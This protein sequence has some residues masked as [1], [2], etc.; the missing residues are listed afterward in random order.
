MKLHNFFLR[1]KMQFLILGVLAIWG[2]YLFKSMATDQNRQKQFYIASGENEEIC[3]TVHPDQELKL[4]FLASEPIHYDIHTHRDDKITY[5]RYE[6]STLKSKSKLVPEQKDYFCAQWKNLGVNKIEVAY[7]LEV[8]PAISN[9][10]FIRKNVAFRVNKNIP[11]VIQVLE[12]STSD[13]VTS[14][15]FLTDVLNFTLNDEEDQLAV[16][17]AGEVQLLRVS[18]GSILKRIAIDEFPSFLSLSGGSKNLVLGNE[19]ELKIVSINLGDLGRT[20]L[21]L[22]APPQSILNDKDS[23][24]LLVRTGSEVLRISFSPLQVIERQARIPLQI[25]EKVQLV[26]PY[27]WCFVHGVPH[28]LFAPVSPAMSETGLVKSWLQPA[29]QDNNQ[30]ALK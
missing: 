25:G 30:A 7:Q 6:T 12:E 2:G 1:I 9:E 26:D 27:A 22:P 8:E 11:Q 4:T 3:L 15:N 21:K 20:E 13:L 17:L 29:N 10:K 28:P 23:E 5:H 18:D 16:L 24:D 14:F 19:H